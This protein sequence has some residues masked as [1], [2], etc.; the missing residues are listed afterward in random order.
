[1]SSPADSSEPGP[2][3]K[4]QR[5]AAS[6]EERKEARAHRN[7][8]AAQN[9]RD[10]RKAQFSHLERR[11]AELEEENRQL[12]AGLVAPPPAPQ[13]DRDR[14]N[15]ELRER[16]RTLEKGWDAVMKALAAQGLPTSTTNNT[17]APA[18]TAPVVAAP[19]PTLTPD[20]VVKQSPQI[21]AFPETTFPLSPAPTVSSLDFDLDLCSTSSFLSTGGVRRTSG[22]PAAGGLDLSFGLGGDA[23]S[24]PSPEEAAIDDATMEDLFREILAPSPRLVAAHLPLDGSAAPAFEDSTSEGASPS[25]AYPPQMTAEDILGLEE[26]VGAGVTEG[27]TKMWTGELEVDMLEMDRILELLPAADAAFQQNLDDLNNLGLAWGD[28]AT[29]P[30]LVGVF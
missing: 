5:T 29:D 16:I 20:V 10:R 4:R 9:S 7:R 15:E 17:T 11:V 26:L 18:P 23:S 1:M 28:V 14:E 12:R 19:E 13:S 30:G 24:L 8:I 22:G 2:S 27:D 25:A 6:S 3:R 21:D